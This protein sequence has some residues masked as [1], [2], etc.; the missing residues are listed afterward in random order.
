M[1]GVHFAQALEAADAP[2]VLPHAF[3]AQLVQDGSQLARVQRIGLG[4]RFLAACRRIDPEQRWPRHVHIA[5]LDQ[6]GKMAKKQCQQ[7]HLDMR[8][9]HV[10]VAQDADL[11]VAQTRQVGRVGRAVR[12]D[13]DGHRDI[14]D[15]GVGKQAV[16]VHFP[17]V[18]HFAA[19]GQNGLRLFVA[20]HFGA[21]TGRVALDQKHFVVRQVAALAVGQFSR[22]HGHAGALA[23]LHLLAGF[24]PRLRGLDGQLGQLA[25]VL[26]MLVQPQ[27]Q[28]R[29]HKARHQAHGVARVQAFLDLALELRVQHLGREH[30]TGACKHILGQQLDTL[31]QQGM[32]LDETL[33]GREQA[34][35]QPAFMRAARAGRNQVDVTLTHRVAVFGKGNTPLRALALCKTVMGCVGKGFAFEQR[36]HRVATEGLHQVVAQATLV[37]PGLGVARFFG[38]QRDRYARHQHRL[39]A[40]QM[41]QIGHRQNAG[42]EIFRVRPD[43][44]RGAGFAVTLDRLA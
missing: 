43:P 22:Q 8:A 20:P 2:G 28:R 44:Y 32:Q 1:F 21:A 4:G 30:V 40:Q 31:G 18:E 17:G 33:D 26:H 14:V 42:L 7:Q 9:I 27:L 41:H 38:G 13:P 23:L 15:L 6:L 12:I 19:Q 29:A 34:L 35:A 39:A 36:Y 10:G 3:L 25:A 11:A 5:V 16:A 37:K 24:L